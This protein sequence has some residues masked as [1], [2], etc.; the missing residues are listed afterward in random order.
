MKKGQIK[1]I[2]VKEKNDFFQALVSQFAITKKDEKIMSMFFELNEVPQ[3]KLTI[4]QIKKRQEMR[5]S[6]DNTLPLK[7]K[8][9]QYHLIKT[10]DSKWKL[11]PLE[12]IIAHYYRNSKSLNELYKQV[13]GK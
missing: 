8:Y 2:N 6:L 4:E 5:E 3:D 9:Y 13:T 10:F 7:E 11:L 1:Q 12:D